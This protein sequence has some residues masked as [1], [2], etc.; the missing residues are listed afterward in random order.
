MSYLIAALSDPTIRGSAAL[1]LGR[2]EARE[3]VPAL[4]RNLR[5]KS[6]LDRN[7][8]VIALRKIGDASAAPAL[9]EVALEDE[10]WGIRTS[11]ID[12]LATLNDPRGMQLL[13]QLA[14]DPQPSAPA[15]RV[16]ST[17]HR[18]RWAA[19]RRFAG[20]AGGRCEGCA[21]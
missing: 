3:A 21:S 8:A 14:I 11:A 15:Q 9:F 4:V 19:G 6:D 20:P 10:A 5:V 17:P 18:D 7:A 2:L 1:A 16:L 13:A 12:A